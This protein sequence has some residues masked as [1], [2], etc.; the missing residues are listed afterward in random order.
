MLY[1]ERNTPIGVFVLVAGIN[2]EDKEGNKTR[3]SV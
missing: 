1:A 3:P 2:K